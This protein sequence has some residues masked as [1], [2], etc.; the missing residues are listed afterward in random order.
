MLTH[1]VLF[2]LHDRSLENK[3]KFRDALET[4][5]GKIPQIRAMQVG[6]NVVESTRAYDVALYQQFDS[7]AAMQE[8][9]THPTHQALLP[10][11]RENSENTVA[12]DYES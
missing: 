1:V 3:Q 12:V 4:L 10:Y 8:Y 9:Q 5:R 7:L 6:V 11:L 2:K